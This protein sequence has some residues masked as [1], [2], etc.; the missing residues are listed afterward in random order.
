[1]SL[2]SRRS[3]PDA[4][5]DAAPQ[6]SGNGADSAPVAG[7][8][9]LKVDKVV[10]SLKGHSQV[11]LAAIESYERDNANRQVVLDKLRYLRTD[12]PLDG[13]DG[14]EPD[15]IAAALRGA[16]AGTLMKVREYERKFK[17]R[18]VVLTMI[19]QVGHDAGQ[20][21]QAVPDSG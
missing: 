5:E 7:Y 20:G 3:S 2:F 13:Y 15:A 14:L 11:E 19:A 10:A 9:A 21:R 12:E 17:R 6:H 1:V 4:G 8:D 18:D 16:D